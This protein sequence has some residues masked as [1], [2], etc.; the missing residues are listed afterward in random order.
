MCV[1]W[2][3]WYGVIYDEMYEWKGHG[4]MIHKPSTQS[5]ISFDISFS[6]SCWSFNIT[7]NFLKVSISSVLSSLVKA[8]R[9][10]LISLIIW[11]AFSYRSR[12]VL[13]KILSKVLLVNR[14]TDNKSLANLRGSTSSSILGMWLLRIWEHSNTISKWIIMRNYA[15]NWPVQHPL[16]YYLIP[17]HFS[18]TSTLLEHLSF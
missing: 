13:V 11:L 6:K 14:P 9:H 2:I 17:I 7:Q 4:G 16:L 8:C 3:V 1:L 12:L 5:I 10:R 15:C 18:L